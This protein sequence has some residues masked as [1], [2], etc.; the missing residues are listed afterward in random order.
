MRLRWNLEET[1]HIFLPGSSFPVRYT[2]ILL[3]FTSLVLTFHQRVNVPEVIVVLTTANGTYAHFMPEGYS[4]TPHEK[5]TMLGSIYW[6][7]ILVQIP[8]GYICST[9][10]GIKLLF[11][12]LFF[13]SFICIVL[14]LS[15]IFGNFITFILLRALQG[16]AQ[17]V[18]FPTI[19]GHLAKWCPLNE[20]SLLGGFSQSGAEFGVAL[21]LMNSGFLSVSS[22]YWPAAF[23]MP[24][25]AGLVWCIF[26]SIFGAESPW[27]SKR[28]S[29]TEKQLIQSAGTLSMRENRRKAAIPWCA[30]A[31]SVPYLVLL[32]NKI[33][34]A[35]TIATMGQQIPIYLNG[36]YAYEI[37]INALISALPFFIML[38]STYMVTIIS[39]YLLK[40]RKVRLSLV[41]KSLNTISN[42]VPATAL[43]TMSL[44]SKDNA[45]GNISCIVI[46]VVAFSTFTLGS[47]LNHIDLAPNFAPLLSGVTGTF[48]MIA[49]IFSPIAVAEVVKDENDPWQWNIIFLFTAA[50]LF[51]TNLLYLFFG[52]MVAQPW[53]EL[54]TKE[55]KSV[56]NEVT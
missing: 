43:A 20:R 23:Y 35:F 24:G 26:W 15:L 13:S 14:P 18:L 55:T 51:V 32:L 11:C 36:M 12:S 33:S 4:L 56:H 44:L 40:V 28:I 2:Q 6:G 29:V 21:G 37:H 54:Q 22:L 30:I 3:L 50:F 9:Y 49:A 41:R 27:V 25:L 53:N 10:G 5:S 17:G 46:T 8:S 31:T 47:S 34:H 39:H 52:Q 38:I 42:W 16:L 7:A 45:V 48:V 1:S 19:F